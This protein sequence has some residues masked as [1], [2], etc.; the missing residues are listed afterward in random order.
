MVSEPYT[1]TNA[2]KTASFIKMSYHVDD[3]LSAH[4]AVKLWLRYRAAVSRRFSMKYVYLEDK[5]MFLEM[6]FHLDLLRELC[7]IEQSA[8]DMWMLMHFNM[9]DCENL[10]VVA[11]PDSDAHQGRHSRE[12]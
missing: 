1:T 7:H 2:T 4:K 9:Q 10:D 6:R 8:L 5:K 11:I 3:G 12:C